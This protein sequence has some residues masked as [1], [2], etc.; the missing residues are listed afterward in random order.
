MSIDVIRSQ[1]EWAI[2]DVRSYRKMCRATEYEKY[3][4]NWY[5]GVV[6]YLHRQL[7]MID[8]GKNER[9]TRHEK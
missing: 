9:V 5:V 3:D 1:V 4:K 2:E 6:M 7:D 8:F